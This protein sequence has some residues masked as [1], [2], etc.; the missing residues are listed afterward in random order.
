MS[1]PVIATPQYDLT[2][3]STGK[4]YKF[5][6][7]LVKEEKIL[8]MA[9]EGED[10]TEIIN[11]VKQIIKACV[12][13]IDVEQ[14]STFDLEYIFLK[15]REKSISDVI[16]LNV[17]HIDG[18]NSKG[19]ECA[20]TQEIKVNL[21]DIEVI[22]EKNHSKKI[23]LTDT[24]G[25]MMKYPTIT[26]IEDMGSF[27]NENAFR[28]IEKCIDFIFDEENNYSLS[29]YSKEEIKAFID[30]LSHQQFAKIE[31]FFDTMP[32]VEHTIKWKCNKCGSEETLVLSGLSDFFI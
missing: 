16:E 15:L 31:E 25:I 26:M 17:R 14:I 12:S 28:L 9:L 30:S 32:R 23:Q 13:K 27:D 4:K 22:T 6:P 18:I 7:F 8:L 5:R 19:E 10:H 11:A 24:I 29:D 21:S 2:L 3:P 20:N 1:L